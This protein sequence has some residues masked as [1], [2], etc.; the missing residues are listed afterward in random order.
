MF[1]HSREQTHSGPHRDRSVHVLLFQ[2]VWTYRTSRLLSSVYYMNSVNQVFLPLLLLE[3]S[4]LISKYT[5]LCSRRGRNLLERTI[6]SSKD[7]SQNCPA[8]KKHGQMN[9]C[10]WLA[11]W[12]HFL[13]TL[14]GSDQPD[15]QI[16]NEGL[17]SQ[18]WSALKVWKNESTPFT[19]RT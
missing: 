16:D 18:T 3:Y 9:G 6:S 17:R 2:H 10:K 7:A 1:P 11:L 15:I 13:F 12:H 5:N 8:T 19:G 4:T 14:I